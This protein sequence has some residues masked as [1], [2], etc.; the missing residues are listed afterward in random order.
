MPIDYG[1]ATATL[2]DLW[3]RFGVE[4]PFRQASPIVWSEVYPMAVHPAHVRP[5]QVMSEPT[6]SL[7]T[8]TSLPESNINEPGQSLGRDSTSTLC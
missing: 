3:L 5:H 6:T 1:D 7:R 4:Q 8:H 2:C